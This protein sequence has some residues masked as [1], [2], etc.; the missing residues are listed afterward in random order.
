MS[1]QKGVSTLIGIIIIVVVAII[2]FGGFFAWQYWAQ[3]SVP[4]INQ[5]ACITE[6]GSYGAPLTS[7]DLCC[8]GLVE[9]PTSQS[10]TSGVC[11]KPTD[12]TAGWKTYTN[13]EYGFEFKYPQKLSLSLSDEGAIT[14]T[15][16]IPFENRDG[17]C[18]M[19]GT[20]VLSE[21]LTDFNLSIN[22]S[23]GLINPPY[24][25][26]EYSKGLLNGKYAYMGVEGCGQTNYYFPITGNRT[27]VVTKSM[28]QI[29]SPVVTPEVRAEVL[30][31]PGVISYEESN[32]ILDGI[33]STFKFTN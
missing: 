20:G 15:H 14:L 31:T 32:K 4:A 27:L 21:T 6:G 7:A 17:G 11:V 25:D 23:P 28:V 12:Q 5:T 29:L 33:L 10:G 9:Q 8:A 19:V 1:N 16:S 24:I 18:D 30:A 2:A 22:V 26:G 13:T 3:K